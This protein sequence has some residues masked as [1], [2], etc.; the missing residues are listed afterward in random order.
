MTLRL[1]SFGNVRKTLGNAAIRMGHHQ[2]HVCS[3]LG[4]SENRTP[5]AIDMMFDA[6]DKFVRECYKWNCKA[7][8]MRY[9]EECEPTDAEWK[10]ICNLGNVVSKAQLFKTLAC[11]DYNSDCDGIVGSKVYETCEWR[12]EFEKFRKTLDRLRSDV[13]ESIAREL[14]D[15][16]GCEWG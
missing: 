12:E 1:E 3:I 10:N 8:S 15:K 4:V 2:V 7:F 16:E 5:L 11:I 14:A 13:A 9:D 6:I